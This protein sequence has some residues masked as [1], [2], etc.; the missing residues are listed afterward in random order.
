MTKYPYYNE[1]VTDT[2]INKN[3]LTIFIVDCLVGLKQYDEALTTI[4]P[5]VIDSYGSSNYKSFVKRA[6]TLIEANYEKKKIASELEVAFKTMKQKMNKYQFEFYWR[7]KTFE[8]FPY[9]AKK[10]ITV[11]SFIA[12]I[13]QADFWLQLTN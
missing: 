10:G 3:R 8:L 6:L 4:V 7:T 12:E 13:K 9:L 5:Q 11:E 2:R 1:S